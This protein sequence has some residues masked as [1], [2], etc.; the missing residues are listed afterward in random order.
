M[1]HR[2]Q[3]I[4]ANLLIVAASALL[5][6]AVTVGYA[7]RA[8]VDS[9]QLANRATAAL[10][11]ES[12]RALVAQQITDELVLANNSDLLAA[13]PLIQSVTEGVV[14][15]SAF[16]SLFRFGV[17]D[18]HRSLFDDSADTLTLAVADVGTVVSAAL[19]QVRPSLASDVRSSGPVK[20]VSRNIGSV[21]SD[22]GYVAE[23]AR[24]LGVFLA[25]LSAVLAIG[26]IALAADRRRAVV[27]LGVGIAVTGIALIVGLDIA[28]SLAVASVE[29][30]DE[31]AAAGAVWDAFLGDLRTIGW[32]VGGIG[33]VL[34]GAATS[35][36]RPVDV[37]EP[38][39]RVWTAVVREPRRPAW[40]AARGAG[41]LVVGFIVLL[42]RDAV[43]ASLMTLTGIYLVYAGTSVLLRLVNR[44][45][46]AAD[47][48]NDP[49]AAPVAIPRGGR[50]TARPMV[51][52]SLAVAVVVVAATAFVGSGGATTDPPAPG[53]CNG[54][55]ELCD[56]ALNDVA[57]AATHNSMSVPLPGWFSSEHERSI[58]DQLRD[59]IRGLLIDTH[60]A[61]ALPNGRV[62]TFFRSVD[63]QR[64]ATEQDGV[65][66]D[67][68]RAA[69]RTRER[70]GFSGQGERGIYLC[71]SFCELGATKLSE[72]LA[73]LR[74][75]AI[76]NP[77]EV[78][79][80]INQ[81]SIT[82]ADFVAAVRE[83]G[84]EQLAYRG[85]LTGKLPSLRAMID[86]GQRI[87][88]LAEQKAGSAPWYRTVYS[89]AVQETPYAFE[90]VSQ[91]TDPAEFAASCTPNRGPES[92]PLFLLNHWVT[93]A[94]LPLPSQ[95]ERVNAYAPLLARARACE[96]VRDRLPN[97][98]AVNFYERGDLLAVVDTLN[99][100]RR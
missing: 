97:L 35:L 74:D 73:Q 40:R 70:L 69:L 53:P 1:R 8:A 82:P 12:V 23:R 68:V 83:A 79:V 86:S 51:A 91:L 44:P 2:R 63:D 66:P 21:S 62:R 58:P 65:N 46:E 87:V 72:V 17:R 5:L 13:R 3:R 90:R 29:G 30:P 38:L 4:V 57:L 9:D 43:L 31:Q 16:A 15:S 20:L 7:Q 45:V 56:R 96:R 27:R 75:F 49:S 67:A 92:A 22:L 84:L 93:T 33:A 94:P 71:H 88:F 6:L 25:L 24:L 54:H 52:S 76:A 95:A 89:E 64:Q 26:A 32:L 81:D 34:A 98:V 61:D 99:G 80:V 48:D 78:M 39:R 59:G 77:N 60:Y 14:G 55:A 100:V 50:L 37:D 18:V 41:L 85:S 36:I 11:D 19:E 28:R 42:D 47:G 10:Q